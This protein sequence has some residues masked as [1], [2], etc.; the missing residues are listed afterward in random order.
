M[1][2]IHKRGEYIMC[3][4]EKET[5]IHY[6]VLGMKWG[7]RRFQPYSKDY[8]GN[9][10]EVGIAK[11]K[12]IGYNDDII[13]KKGA[14]AYRITADKNENGDRRYVTI[15]QNDRNFYKGIWPSTMKN[16]SQV[17]DRNTRM[18][19]S[20]YRTKQ[21]LISPSA[22]KRQKWASDLTETN[23]VQKEIART[24][25][26]KRLAKGN[27][28]SEKTMRSWMVSWESKKDPAYI[29]ALK[30]K[31]K[32]VNTMIKNM[33]ELD[34]AQMFLGAI[35]PSDNLKMIYG[36]KIV[37]EHY[38]MVIDDHGADFAGNSCR[39]NAPIIVFE[40]NKTLSKIKDKPLS[41][42]DSRRALRK[43]SKDISSIP[44]TM[45]EIKFVPNVVKKSYGLKN[46]YENPYTRD[47]I[48]DRD[49]NR[50]Y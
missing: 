47:W 48:Y 41:A 19:E 44:G 33:D 31:T 16:D 26:C 21:D 11:K 24:M 27:N 6:G 34:K 38:N 37:K 17:V 30:E 3:I 29:K 1:E 36:K 49:G 2:L 13:I 9:G 12:S 45:S 23:E 40:A 4:T 18:Y 42:Y 25:M 22:A 28:V 39:V 50:M 7:V 15:D 20:T 8:T 5:L 14:K 10:K 43:Y 32:E 35:G 46:Y